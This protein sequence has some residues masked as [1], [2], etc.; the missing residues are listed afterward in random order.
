M[1]KDVKWVPFPLLRSFVHDVFRGV[2][3]PNED[4]HICTDVLLEADLK[5]LDTH[6]VNRLKPVYYDR[7]RAELQSPVTM[8][9]MVRE[10]PTTAVVDGNNGMGMVVAKRSMDLC[11]EKAKELG[12]GM[13]AVRNSTHF[14]IAGYYSEMAAKRGLIGIAG[15]NARPSIA[16]TFSVEPMLGTNPLT[17]AFPTDEEFPFSL[18]CATSIIQRGKVELFARWG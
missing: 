13:V 12:M 15:T 9:D 8:L 18:D 16:P 10:G 1:K 11:I 3:V 2:G 4:A 7:V 17:F 6:G 5:G 14:G